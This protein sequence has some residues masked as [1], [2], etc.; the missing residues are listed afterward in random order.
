MG[1]I[2]DIVESVKEAFKPGG[3][4]LSW[5]GSENIEILEEMSNAVL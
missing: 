2:A 3:Y 5:R 4:F 1:L